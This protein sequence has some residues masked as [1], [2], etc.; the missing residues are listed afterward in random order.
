MARSNGLF[1][2]TVS[3]IDVDLA[4]PSW[5]SRGDAPYEQVND[6]LCARAV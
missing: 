2:D 6:G 5:I 3:I 4:R 1:E